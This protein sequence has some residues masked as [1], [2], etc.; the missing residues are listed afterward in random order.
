MLS[1]F[2]KVKERSHGGRVKWDESVVE[3]PPSK[4]PALPKQAARRGEAEVNHSSTTKKSNDNS[5]ME[6]GVA[7]YT[8]GRPVGGSPDRGRGSP[9]ANLHVEFA[10]LGEVKERKEKYLTAK[11]G[12]HQMSLIR[13]RLGVEMWMFDQLQSLYPTPE[14]KNEEKELDL[15]ELLDVDDDVKRRKFLWDTLSDCKQSKDKVE[16]FIDELLERATTL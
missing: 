9:R 11:Y 8:S 6:V 7:S 4:S 1:R 14:G 12:A 13:K 10:Q 15:D 16:K 2:R 5:G 3:P